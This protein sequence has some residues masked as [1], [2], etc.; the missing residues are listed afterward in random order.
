LKV[1]QYDGP[2]YEMTK[3]DLEQL[4]EAQRTGGYYEKPPGMPVIEVEAETILDFGNSI[5]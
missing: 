2:R 1:I 4:R 5:L 3:E